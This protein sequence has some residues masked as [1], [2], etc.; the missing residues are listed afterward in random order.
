[1]PALSVLLLLLFLAVVVVVVDDLRTYL[2]KPL[3]WQLF[4][5]CQDFA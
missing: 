1:M 4:R 3:L 2:L 5:A